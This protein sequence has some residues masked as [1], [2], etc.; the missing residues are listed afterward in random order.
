VL[1]LREGEE[2]RLFNAEDGEWRARLAR[3]ARHDAAAALTERLR[4]AAAEPGPTLVFA[5]LRR[6]RLDWLVEKAV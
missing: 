2:V 3:L 1:R 6:N 5:P 4:P